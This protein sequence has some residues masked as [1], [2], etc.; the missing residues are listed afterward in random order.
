MAPKDIVLEDDSFWDDEIV[1]GY[2]VLR[3]IRNVSWPRND[4][5]HDGELD[6]AEGLLLTSYGLG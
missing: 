5:L 2:E 4:E 6:G 1:D 3:E